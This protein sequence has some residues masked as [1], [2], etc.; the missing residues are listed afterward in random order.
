MSTYRSMAYSIQTV[1]KQTFDDLS[2]DINQIVYWINL[3]VKRARYDKIKKNISDA[4]LVYFPD[5]KI[6]TD[7]LTKRKYIILPS[8]IVDLDNDYGIKMIT[9]CADDRD[10]CEEPL[11]NP[12]TRT[13]AAKVNS[14]YGNPF[15][16][17]STSN[18]VF[19]RTKYNV[20]GEKKDV[21]F[22]LGIECLDIDCVDLYLYS[23]ESTDFICNLDE[24]ID[25]SPEMEKFIYYEVLNLARFGYMTPSDK[26]NDG[27]DTQYKLAQGTRPVQPI[28]RDTESPNE[29]PQQQ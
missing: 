10:V 24:K 4:Y 12:F 23:D 16:K 3:M 13:Q 25:I 5:V 28:Y 2:V 15:R 20:N 17:P 1:I 18:V 8:T 21:V 26:T 27:N 19:Y 9:F 22:F 11:E 14:L 29:Q 7:E 6:F